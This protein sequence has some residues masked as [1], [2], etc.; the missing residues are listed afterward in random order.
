[1]NPTKEKQSFIKT[2]KKI[3]MK[4]SYVIIIIIIIFSLH[5]G[6]ISPELPSSCWVVYEGR[7]VRHRAVPPWNKIFQIFLN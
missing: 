7:T 4:S 1:M 2:V 6:N 5:V 3:D